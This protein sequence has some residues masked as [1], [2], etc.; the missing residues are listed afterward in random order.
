[1]RNIL[2]GLKGKLVDRERRRV[3][4]DL[5]KEP[6][7]ASWECVMTRACGIWEYGKHGRSYLVVKM[8]IVI[9]TLLVS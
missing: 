5:G 4:Q 9:I 2:P 3:F 1:M 7:Q 8:T 6:E